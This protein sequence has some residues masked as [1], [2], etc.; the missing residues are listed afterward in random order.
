MAARPPSLINRVTETDG[1]TDRDR[2]SWHDGEVLCYHA[3]CRLLSLGGAR[4]KSDIT[5]VDV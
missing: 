1:D 2:V 5:S 4:L 3:N